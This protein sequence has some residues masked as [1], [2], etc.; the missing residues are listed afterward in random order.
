MGAAGWVSGGGGGC[1]KFAGGELFGFGF[2]GHIEKC[3]LAVAFDRVTYTTGRFRCC[4][5]AGP[6]VGTGSIVGMSRNPL[7][8]G[9]GSGSARDTARDPA[10]PLF[11]IG[12]DNP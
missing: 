12:P 5:H 7:G 4:G 2:W 6:A 8:F 9:F 3:A 1:I 10:H 11:G